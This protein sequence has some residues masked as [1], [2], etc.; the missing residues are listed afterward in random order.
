ML[1]EIDPQASGAIKGTDQVT[2][3]QTRDTYLIKSLFEEAITSSQLEGASTTRDVAKEMLQRGLS[4]RDRS[5][6]M[7]Y[8]NYQAMEFIRRLGP[9]ALTPK[10]VFELHRILTERTLD[11]AT[12]A[13][14]L[15]R[16]DE[17]IHVTD[18]VGRTLHVPPVAKELPD[19]V[20]AMC[21]F[22]NGTN[23]KPFLHPTKNRTYTIEARPEAWPTIFVLRRAKMP[24]PTTAP[25]RVSLARSNTTFVAVINPSYLS[26]VTAAPP[27]T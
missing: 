22:A 5:E 1:H 3:P 10:I 17:I 6:Q 7:I 21:E 16:P 25:Q 2:D 14:R 27:F 13:G 4:P 26:L 24:T 20:A 8:N 18:E 23:G 11:D 15:R 19:R 9:V 12:A